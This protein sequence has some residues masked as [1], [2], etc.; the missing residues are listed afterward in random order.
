MA[1]W[2]SHS[3]SSTLDEMIR[4]D[5]RGSYVQSLCVDCSK[6][7]PTLRCNDC[8]GGELFCE[9]CLVNLHVRNPLHNITVFISLVSF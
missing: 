8:F 3:R 5:G 1:Q 2:V 7:Q 4:L 9:E 6:S